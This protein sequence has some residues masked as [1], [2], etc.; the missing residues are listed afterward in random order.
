MADL[1]RLNP[2][3]FINGDRNRLRVGE[4]LLLPDSVAAGASIVSAAAEPAAPAQVRKEQPQAPSQP[5]SPATLAEAPAG[6]DQSLVDVLRQLEA[7]VLSLQAQ[8]DEQNRLLAEA[9]S[10][11]AQRQAATVAVE[12]TV[13]DATAVTSHAEQ[14]TQ[15][16]PQTMPV[17]PV[18]MAPPMQETS[19]GS[20]WLIPLLGLLSLLVGLLWYRRRS[21]AVTGIGEPR[22]AQAKRA[23]AS[24]PDINPFQRDVPVVTEMSYDEYLDRTPAVPAAPAGVALVAAQPQAVQQPQQAQLL[25]DMLASLPD[26]LDALTNA[27]PVAAVEAD[28]RERLNEAL[29]SIDRGEVD[30][31][32]RLLIALL[33]QS[34]SDDRR[35]IGEQLARIA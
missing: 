4:E 6:P 26:D 10:T 35:F 5:A 20:S 2:A 25:D 31:A 34:D 1:Y 19:T 16:K 12:A 21:V 14:P 24:F 11:L 27:P 23:E 17:Q 7:Q 22:Q 30:Q 3:A 28:L 32:T 9:Q 13:Q 8:M 29:A 15:Q 33:D 18:A